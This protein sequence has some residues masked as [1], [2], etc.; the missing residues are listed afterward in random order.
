MK[1]S[2]DSTWHLQDSWVC[3]CCNYCHHY[4]CSRGEDDD[5]DIMMMIWW[6]FYCNYYVLRTE[7]IDFLLLD[8][9]K[10]WVCHCRRSVSYKQSCR[11]KAVPCVSFQVIFLFEKENPPKGERAPTLEI[12]WQASNWYHSLQLP[13]QLWPHWANLAR[14]R[15]SMLFSIYLPLET[16]CWHLGI[17][18]EE[19]RISC[20]IQ[21]LF[22]T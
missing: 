21:M 19:N 16:I 22:N 7:I 12:I 18:K 8:T 6:F 13:G 10:R 4:H 14:V 20:E 1:T 2:W 9:S 15:S 3:G 17:W 5:K 11:G